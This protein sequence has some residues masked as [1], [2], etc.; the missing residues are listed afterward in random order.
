MKPNPMLTRNLF[1]YVS[2]GEQCYEIN[3]LYIICPR[4]DFIG[5]PVSVNCSPT[6]LSFSNL[7]VMLHPLCGA[8]TKMRY[9]WKVTKIMQC[10]KK[11]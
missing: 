7:L 11:A 8:M 9:T 2:A 3:F 10:E 5:I 4:D 1:L 6:I